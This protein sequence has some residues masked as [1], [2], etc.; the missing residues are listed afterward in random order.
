MNVGG[1]QIRYLINLKKPILV[2]DHW[3]IPFMGGQLRLMKDKGHTTGL[4]AIFTGQPIK[5]APKAALD[6]NSGQ[7]TITGRDAL[8][9]FVRILLESAFAFLQC[10]FDVEIAIDQVEVQFSA[11]TE[12]EKPAIEIHS[13][14]IDK[15][16]RP[17]SIS[18]DFFTRAIMA[19][20]T[21]GGPQFEA[22]LV[23][24]ARHALQQEKYI[25][26]F[27][28]S[29]LLIEA[30]YGEGKFKTAQLKD[31]L[32]SNADFVSMV[33]KVLQEKLPTKKSTGSDTEVL[34]KSAP[35]PQAVIEHLVD[36]RGFY[37][38]GNVKHKDAWKP[39]DQAKAEALAL[40]AME[41]AMLISH[42]AAA[43]MFEDQLAKRHYE[44][45]K[46]AGAIMSLN[47]EFQFQEPGEKSD[48]IKSVNFNV[49]GTKVT[50]RM[51]QYVAQQALAR[52]EYN[53]PAGALKK[54]T[55]TANGQKVFEMTFF[56]EGNTQ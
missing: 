39:H 10:Y 41:I 31:A 18:F 32:K 49:P 37:F 6:P 29:F 5:Y 55:C 9:P 12:A 15:P 56:A 22:T 16:H 50:P 19:A 2:E 20:E 46:Q 53:S 8:F 24:A 27:R 11:E 13:M 7:M 33:A 34:L 3:P 38:H 25:D 28:Y 21:H 43:P 35:T 54:A 45:A 51:A 52:F 26:S 4:E 30:L 36:K 47:V 40:I 14:S 23:I 42:E 44:N 1:M 17:P 48:Q